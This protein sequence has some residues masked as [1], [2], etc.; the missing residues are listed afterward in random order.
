MSTLTQLSGWASGIIDGI[1]DTGIGVSRTVTWLKSNLGRLNLTIGSN[2]YY[3]ATLEETL[4]D[5]M[6]VIQSG[7][8]EEMFYCNYLDKKIN[9]NLGAGAYD[10][11]E[12]QGEDQGTIRKA[13]RTEVGKG[14]A[15]LSKDC[16]ERLATFVSWYF[17]S[18]NPMTP[19]QVLY[20]ERYSNNEAGLLYPPTE[21]IRNSNSVFSNLY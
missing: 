16:K 18:T 7:I 8:Y 11:I 2:F 10:W 9:E 14:Y 19:Y 3:D 1:G 17:D 21:L 6:T 13:S 15:A 12:I 20:N 5:D 4:P